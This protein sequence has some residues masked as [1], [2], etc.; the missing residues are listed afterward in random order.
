MPKDLKPVYANVALI[1]HGENGH[2][3]R[4]IGSGGGNYGRGAGTASPGAE[5][6][7]AYGLGSAPSNYA[8]AMVRHMHRYGNSTEDYAHIA[9]V[10]RDWATLNPRAAMYSKLVLRLLFG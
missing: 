4:K 2:S 5:M 7:M 10:T 3:A 6:T 8:H 1:S 9:K